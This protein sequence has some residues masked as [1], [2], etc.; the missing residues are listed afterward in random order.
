L[1]SYDAW[2]KQE[3][4]AKYWLENLIASDHLEDLYVDR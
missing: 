1:E 2:G 3:M 4:H